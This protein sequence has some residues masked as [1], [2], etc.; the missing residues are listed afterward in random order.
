[1]SLIILNESKENCSGCTACKSICPQNAIKME[2]D[3]KGFLYPVIDSSLCVNCGLCK[4]VCDFSCFK[5]TELSPTAYAVKHIDED[6]VATSRSGAVFMSLCDFVLKNGGVVCGCE[7]KDKTTIIH[8][9]QDTKNGINKFKG[10]KYVQSNKQNCFVKCAEVLNNDK[11]LLFSGTGCEVH[12]FLS[13]CKAKRINMEKLITCDLVCHGA[14]SP[15]V[16]KAYVD[17]MEKRNRK[18]VK[19]VDFR[20]KKQHGWA[21][22]FE[23]FVWSDA[24]TTT[25]NWTNNF[26][27]HTLFRESC[28]NCKYTTPNRKTDFTI[29]DCWGVEKVAPEFDDNKGVS[30]LMVRTSKAKAIFNEMKHE[31]HCK[32]IPLELVMQPQL[33][34]PVEKG[35]SYDLF[36]NLF[37]HNR[38]KCMSIFFF[39]SKVRLFKKKI[40]RCGDA[41]QRVFLRIKEGM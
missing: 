24:T 29:A 12:G 22:H 17:E 23:T 3:K 34:H 8:T 15:L 33:L 4:S 32:Q 9:I 36:W 10:S 37:R 20:D 25:T 26:Y 35:E 16:W 39:P 28:Y 13:Y 1:M 7:L 2:P 5:P 27:A 18:L 41:L 31:L 19:S 40:I 21:A 38:R 30:L 14:P 6:E 11:W